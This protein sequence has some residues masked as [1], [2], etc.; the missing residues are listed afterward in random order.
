MAHL[1]MI[2]FAFAGVADKP[3]V[4]RFTL[5][6]VVVSVL[7]MVKVCDGAR[8]IGSY[9]LFQTYVTCVTGKR[10]SYICPAR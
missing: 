5:L 8:S 6:W 10:K 9:Y 1:D 3:F 7:D 4:G 2:V